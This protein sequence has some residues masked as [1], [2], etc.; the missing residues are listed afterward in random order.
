M[1]RKLIAMTMLLVFA[2]MAFFAAAE[3][4][5]IEGR[6]TAINEKYGNIDTDVSA[7]DMMKLNVNQ[8][9]S[10]TITAGDRH[11]SVYLGTTY[12]DVPKGDWVAFLTTDGNIRI[13]RNFDNAAKALGVKVGD[14]I[15]ITR[16]Q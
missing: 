4:A 3:N 14:S 1:M 2:G 9:D 7:Q 15:S 11:F 8:G 6:V 5:G 10:V 12:S 13:A 16:D